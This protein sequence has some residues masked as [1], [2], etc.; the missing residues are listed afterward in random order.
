MSAR[1]LRQLWAGQFSFGE[2]FFA[3]L[4]GPAFVF[5]PVGIAIAGFMA[6]VAPAQMM[7]SIVIMTMIYALYFSATLPAVVKTG[8]AA[9]EVGGWRWFG[10]FLGVA[11]TVA[12][13][14]SAYK[15]AVAL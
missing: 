6:V 1:W 14:I 12:L 9:K 4:F 2:T 11:A 8:L 7:L 13:W 5:I 10:I 3:G 15:I